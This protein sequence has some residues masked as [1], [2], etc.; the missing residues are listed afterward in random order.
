M[1]TVL[2]QEA[3]KREDKGMVSHRLTTRALEASRTED[4]DELLNEG[5]THFRIFKIVQ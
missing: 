2:L 4:Y 5:A 1:M 3:E